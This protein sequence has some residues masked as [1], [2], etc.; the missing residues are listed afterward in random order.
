L[1]KPVASNSYER[2][3]R[4]MGITY[5]KAVD[6]LS[7][8]D[9]GQVLR[10]WS[11]LGRKERADLLVQIEKLD[12]AAIKRMRQVLVKVGQATSAE[13]IEP[14]VIQK[15]SMTG[16]ACA[17]GV[18]EKALAS[19]KVGALLVAGGQGSRLG[20]EG[21]KGCFPIGPVSGASLFE[22]HSRKI[23]ALEK[24]HSCSIPFYIMTSR[25]NNSATI[26]FFEK[27]DYF[28]LCRE[29]VLFFIQGMWPALS[30]DGRVILDRAEHIFMSPDGHGGTLSALRESGMLEDMTRRKLTTIFYFQVDNPL[31]EIA[32]P[33]F[34]GLHNVRKADMS[35]KV[36]G[37]RHANEGLGVVVVSGGRNRIV[38]YTELTD[39]QKNARA[40]NGQLKYNAGSVAIHMF[41]LKFL[42]RA[43]SLALPLHAAHKKVPVCNEK[44]KLVKPDAPNA[45]KFEKFIFDALPRAKRAMIL[46]FSRDEE[47]SPVKNAS[48]DDSPDTARRDMVRKAARLMAQCGVAVP[49]GKDGNPKYLIEI[50]PCFAANADELRRKLPPKFKIKGDVLLR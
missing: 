28:G 37:K 24:L 32:D 29:R 21:P 35:V 44:G 45:Y 12:F 16:L 23:L 40:R 7:E 41:S 11:K 48:G 50:D 25:D 1:P 5:K 18:G 43:A 20:F 13:D 38:E 2:I 14:A 3:R 10:F 26:A 22:I 17:R 9:Q 19:G 39:E 6:V 47:F 42:R 33:V 34:V 15:T 31:V 4:D 46:E 27:N 8:N 30:P 49:R 36:C